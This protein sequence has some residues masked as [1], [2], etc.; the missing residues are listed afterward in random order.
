VTVKGIPVLGKAAFFAERR[1][2]ADLGRSVVLS[3]VSPRGRAARR[4]QRMSGGRRGG[5]RRRACATKRMHRRTVERSTRA[6]GRRVLRSVLRPVR[7]DP[8]YARTPQGVSWWGVR[9]GITA[10]QTRASGRNQHWGRT[11]GRSR[12]AACHRSREGEGVARQKRKEVE[13]SVPARIE[14]SGSCSHV[15]FSVAEVGR[16]R[17]ASN[18]LGTRAPKRAAGSSERGPSS[19]RRPAG[20]TVGRCIERREGRE[21]DSPAKVGRGSAQGP[22]WRESAIQRSRHRASGGAVAGPGL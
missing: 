2:N 19:V 14:S 10:G 16:R 7:V 22:G 3:R 13:A 4:R 18:K 9:I 20:E 21:S 6:S 12:L 15:V 1:R 11:D 5:E 8:H 17:L